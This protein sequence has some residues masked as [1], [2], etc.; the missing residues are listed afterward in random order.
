[1]VNEVRLWKTVY[2]RELTELPRLRLDLEERIEDWLVD[3]VSIFDPYLLV[4][5]RQVKRTLV[6]SSTCHERTAWARS[7]G[8]DGDYPSLTASPQ[9]RAL[10]QPLVDEANREFTRAE[11]IKRFAILPRDFS[12]DEGEITPTLK[13][14]RRSCMQHFEPEIE[15]L[16]AAVAS[17]A[18]A[19]GVV[20]PQISRARAS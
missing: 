15:A 14:K 19:A 7:Q 11:Q 5:G 1:M 3:D 8:I 17:A 13:L 16:Y 18:Q 10:A 4:I 20:D 6:D 9:V 2:R 12:A